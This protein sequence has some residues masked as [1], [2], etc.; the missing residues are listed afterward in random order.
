MDNVR[1]LICDFF[2]CHSFCTEGRREWNVRRKL[3]HAK[4]V[5]PYRCMTPHTAGKILFN[6]G[7]L[8][9]KLVKKSVY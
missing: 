3:L 6:S 7:I 1:S 9:L 4:F 2:I 8:M 5:F